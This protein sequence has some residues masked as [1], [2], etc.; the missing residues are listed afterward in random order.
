MFILKKK[1]L[2]NALI[3]LGLLLFGG[4]TNA[5]IIKSNA[6]MELDTMETSIPCNTCSEWRYS[7]N[8][9]TLYRFYRNLDQWIAFTSGGGGS[10]PGGLSGYVQFNNS[11][12]F[13]GDINFFWNNTSKS[14][15]IGTNSPNASAILDVSSL[16]KGVLIPRMTTLQKNAI[17]TPATG[18][19]VYDTNLNQ[20]NVYNGSAWTAL[21][22]GVTD[23]DKGDIDVTLN[24]DLW[25]VDTAAITTEKLANK[26]V[27]TDK[28]ALV[29]GVEGSYTN[30]NITVDST[31]R[32]V[33]AASGTGGGLNGTISTGQVAFGS[34]ADTISG[35]NNLFWDVTDSEL[36]IGTNVP[37]ARVQ[38]V[39]TGAT[40]ATNALLIEDS[41]GRDLL[42]IDNA[43]RLEISQNPTVTTQNT[44]VITN[45]TTNSSVVIAPNG[46]GAFMLDIPDGGVD[47]GNARGFNAVDLQTNRNV[48]TQVATGVASIILGGRRNTAT[49]NYSV[50]AGDENTASGFASVA[51]SG[52]NNAATT[53]YT[54][55]AGE[56]ANATLYAQSAYSNGFFSARGDKQ[57][58]FIQLSRAITGQSQNELFLNGSTLRAVLRATNRVWNANIQ[59]TGV[60]SVAGD[61]T[62]PAGSSLVQNFELGIKRVGTNT[63]MLNVIP[64]SISSSGD[65]EMAG[66]TF[67]VDAD[68][69]D[70]T[71][72]ALRIQ[73]TPPTAAGTTTVTRCHCVVRLSEVG[74]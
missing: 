23:G 67:T 32:I 62:V 33:T 48:A 14:L 55:A 9:N 36:G 43:G 41:A 52:F 42:K 8:N 16:S 22:G 66:A 30:A 68:D 15:G 1:V 58:S 35:S 47:G 21:G 64:I 17:S 19:L 12:L 34:G 50:A 25:T 20:V 4:V 11:G 37:T 31:G 18:L 28:L 57:Y 10:T 61:G 49:G 39:G 46:T 53:N 56:S 3:L 38:I 73:F 59:C 51:I 60:V 44:A 54:M 26:S 29:A 6:I 2:Y 5:Q 40:N 24:G 71:G 63:T 74:Y 70:V 7:R 45:T 69:T 27:T 72:E 13:G 65:T